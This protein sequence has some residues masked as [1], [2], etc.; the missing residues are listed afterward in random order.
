MTLQKK[1]YTRGT[2]RSIRI[3]QLAKITTLYPQSKKRGNYLS[4][5][6]G[7]R[8]GILCSAQTTELFVDLL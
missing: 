5:I 1:V 7:K 3:T 4:C 6:E 8:G 2:L